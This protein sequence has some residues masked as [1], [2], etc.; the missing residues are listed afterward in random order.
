MSLSRE[1][2]LAAATNAAIYDL[3][4]TEPGYMLVDA[5][6]LADTAAC[7][8]VDAVLRGQ[9]S[10]KDIDDVLL[11]LEWNVDLSPRLSSGLRRAFRAAWETLEGMS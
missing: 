6:L 5:L 2:L 3:A 9:I 4:G 7:A 1:Q 8:A 11:D 10:A